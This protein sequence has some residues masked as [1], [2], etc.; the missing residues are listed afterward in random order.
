MLSK[1]NLILAAAPTEMMAAQSF[2]L[3]LAHMAYRVGGGPHLFRANLPI[4]ARGG[5]MMIDDAGFDGRGDPGPFCQEV[6]RECTARGYTGVI[7]GF[8]R[9]FPLL[10]RVIAELSPLLER[11]GWPFYISEVYARYSDTAKILIPTALSGGSLHQ[12][13]E[14]A[15]AQYGASRIAL[16]VERAAEDFFLPSPTGQ[17]IPLSQEALQARIEERSP[18]IFFSG[19]LC[20]H[21]FTYMNKQNGAHFILF[22][23]ASSIRKKLHVART[24]D[25]SDA[26]LP[27]PEVADIL[28]EILA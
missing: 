22:D 15:A 11:Q 12:R 13:L 20:A 26:L 17:G 5:L 24:L 6:M 25:I 28:P 2:G 19:E 1:S 8:D 18:T 27:Y 23:D 14:E 4:P 7:C 21:Y 3:T 9:P 16:A 10:G